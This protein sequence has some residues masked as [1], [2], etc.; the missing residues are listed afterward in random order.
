MQFKS[1]DS[2]DPHARQL[3]AV[4]TAW[5][6]PFWDEEKGLL[7]YPGFETFAPLNGPVSRQLSFLFSAPGHSTG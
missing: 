2:L 5:M 3:V 6:D 4:S 7:W 1:L